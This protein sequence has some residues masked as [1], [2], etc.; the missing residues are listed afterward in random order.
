[1]RSHNNILLKGQYCTSRHVRYLYKNSVTPYIQFELNFKQISMFKTTLNLVTH[2]YAV[3]ALCNET[4][5]SL[6][7]CECIGNVVVLFEHYYYSLLL[8]ALSVS[9]AY[10]SSTTSLTISWTLD[11]SV[12]ATNYSISYSNTDTDCFTD[13][14]D[15]TDIAA[16]ET[17]YTL[18]D[19]Q[20]GT[21]YSITVTAL[22]SDGETAEDS[23]T[24]T[25]TAAG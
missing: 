24:T 1:M 16:S 11:D 18:T 6:Q 21:E 23:L 22:L 7:C 5:M 12:T 15:V 2:I 4:V 17:M 14:D 20:E 19:L 13:S 25:T 3:I 8:D 9:V 10:T